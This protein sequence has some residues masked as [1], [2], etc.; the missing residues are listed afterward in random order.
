MVQGGIEMDGVADENIQRVEGPSE[1]YGD[2]CD[3]QRVEDTVLGGAEP[4]REVVERYRGTAEAGVVK[5]TRE[6][7]G[8]HSGVWRRKNARR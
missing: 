7:E 8:T 2:N 6:A 1:L 4:V 3:N 5:N